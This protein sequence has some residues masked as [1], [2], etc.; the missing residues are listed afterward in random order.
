MADSNNAPA[1]VAQKILLLPA[2]AFFVRLL[3]LV[4]GEEVAPQVEI[5]LENLSPFPRTQ[6]YYGYILSSAQ[7]SALIFA[8]YQKKFSREEVGRWVTAEAVLPEFLGLLGEPPVIPTIRVWHQAGRSVAAAWS[9]QDSLPLAVVASSGDELP[10]VVQ[11]ALVEK[12]QARTGLGLAALQVYHGAGLIDY[13]QRKN[14][15]RLTLSAET[16][17]EVLRTVWPQTAKETADVRDPSFLQEQR[18]LR[19][20]DLQLWRG[21]VFCLAGLAAALVVEIGLVAG[22][23]WLGRAQTQIQRRADAVSQIETAQGLS[24]RIEEL[25]QKQ[26]RPFE[27]LALINALRPPSIQFHRS[28]TI[29][30]NKLEVEAQTG[31][32]AD[33]S[34][35]EKQ[36]R[37]SAALTAVVTRDLRSRDG[38]TTF[39]L[40]ITFK[41]E[42]L[43]AVTRS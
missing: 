38:V 35:Y 2:D 23:Q 13:D 27:M 36:L 33:V 21:L 32:A 6:L 22:R 15:I 29:G 12:L 40:T 41:P 20:R 5:A 4:A 28:I 3:P 18:Q 37:D 14:M 25:T 9:G 31:N 43:R 34:K 19:S 24:A 42:A 16:Q 10:T 17:G 8:A 7:T 1:D 26:L 39:I 30:V 11:A